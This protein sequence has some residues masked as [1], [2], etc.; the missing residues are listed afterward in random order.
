MLSTGGWYMR[1]AEDIYTRQDS[2]CTCLFSGLMSAGIPTYDY[3]QQV[4]NCGSAK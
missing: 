1:I 2:K 4:M 3:L